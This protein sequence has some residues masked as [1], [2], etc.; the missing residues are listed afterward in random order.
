MVSNIAFRH[1]YLYNFT[2]HSHS[3]IDYHLQIDKIGMDLSI[4][5]FKGVFVNNSIKNDEI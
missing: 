3:D 4:L 2:R 5:Y 1:D